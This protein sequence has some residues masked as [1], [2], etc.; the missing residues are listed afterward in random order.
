MKQKD[1]RGRRNWNGASERER[2][3]RER[4]YVYVGREINENQ[5]KKKNQEHRVESDHP[6]EMSKDWQKNRNMT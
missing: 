6:M 2:S 1:E 5:K 4:K 3:T